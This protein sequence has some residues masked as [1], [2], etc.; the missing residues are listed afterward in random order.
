V[1]ANAAWINLDLL[2]NY[3]AMLGASIAGVTVMHVYLSMWATGTVTNGDGVRVGLL[4]DD[5]DQVTASQTTL[6]S[7]VNPHDDPYT[8]W[9]M[10]EQRNAHPHYSM[11]GAVDQWHYSIRSKRKIPNVQKTLI[12]S[13]YNQDVA[14]PSFPFAIYART[15]LALP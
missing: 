11:E 4:V 12:W 8:Q 1:T 2:A 5:L 13:V 9:M 6:P 10:I 15:L 14:N 7:V 3:K